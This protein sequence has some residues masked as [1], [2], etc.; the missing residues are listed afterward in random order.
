[1]SIRKNNHTNFGNI[2]P[3]DMF[4]DLSLGAV[5]KEFMMIK[6][7]DE[8]SDRYNSVYIVDGTQWS[9]DDGDEVVLIK[10]VRLEFNN[11]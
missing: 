6:L 4:I 1:M 11:E 10:E 8:C 3:G 9:M 2:E 5:R 7:Y